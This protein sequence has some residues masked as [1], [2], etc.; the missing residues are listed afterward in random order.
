MP[1]SGEMREYDGAHSMDSVD[2]LCS[3]GREGGAKVREEK[4]FEGSL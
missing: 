1:S 2:Y 4:T 3:D